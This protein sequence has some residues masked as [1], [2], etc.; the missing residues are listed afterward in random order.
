MFYKF[1]FKLYHMYGKCIGYA[2]RQ[3]YKSNSLHFVD[4]YNYKIL[5]RHTRLLVCGN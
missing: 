2:L 4:L 1:R 3:F 5:F